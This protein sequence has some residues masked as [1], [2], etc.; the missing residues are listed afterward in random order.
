MAEDYK[1]KKIQAGTAELR[2][3][4][5]PNCHRPMRGFNPGG[6]EAWCCDGSGCR[7]RGVAYRVVKVLATL[8]RE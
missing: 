1:P 5:C 2:S 3:I 4:A 7:L 8:E 6:G